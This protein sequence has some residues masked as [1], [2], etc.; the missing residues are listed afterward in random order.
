MRDSKIISGFNADIQ[1]KSEGLVLALSL[2][3]NKTG[4]HWEAQGKQNVWF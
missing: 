3:A 2:P 1:R 4:S